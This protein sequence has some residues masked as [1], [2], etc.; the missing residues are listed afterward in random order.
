MNME[1]AYRF[2][3]YPTAAQC[4]QMK[5]TFGCCRFVWNHFLD[6]RKKIFEES[7]ETLNFAKCCKE[8]TALKKELPWLRE[9]DSTALQ[10]SLRAL[11]MAF[12]NFFRRCKKGGNPGFPRFKSKHDHCQSYTTKQNQKTI[13]VFDNRV[14]LP[15]L[16]LV[17]CRVS[18]PVQGRILN[19]SVE[20]SASG[21]Y[22][23]SICCTDVQ[24]APLE[25]TGRTVGL[26]MGL[27]DFA[28]SSEGIRYENPKYLARSLRRLARLQRQ[29]SRK[30]KGSR[31]RDKARRLVA[32]LHEHVR[33]QRE[34]AQ[35]KLSTRLVLDYDV[36]CLED[37]AVQNMEKNRHL[38]R[39]IADVSWSAFRRMLEYKCRMGGKKLV[40]VDRFY[41][42]SQLCSACGY[43]NEQVKNLAMRKWTCPEC[44]QPHDRDINAA[45]N[46]KNEGLRLLA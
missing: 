37:L 30:T 20:L 34:D 21:K 2:R 40:V 18:R 36:I 44:G 31:R 19:A 24:P 5:K 14:Q 43:R 35:Q 32:R 6:R 38:A 4:L 9:A 42:S 27:T 22:F 15:K 39:A 7:G 10:S 13:K 16:G 17:K 45:V 8:L 33:N 41:P 11:D 29:L 26:D 25:K 28:V 12:Q 1:K 46:I 3:I 23:V